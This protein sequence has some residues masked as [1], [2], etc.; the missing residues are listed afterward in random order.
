MILSNQI[1]NDHPITE[2]E[3]S[4]TLAMGRTP[5]REA[6]NLL[7]KDGIIQLIPNKGFILRQISYED[8]IQIYQIR[9]VLDPLA[10]RLST[11]RIDLSKLEE[12]EE[13]Y[14]RKKSDWESSRQFSQELHSLIYKSCGNPYLIEMF[15]SLDFRIEAKRN[16]AWNL[17]IKFNDTVVIERRKQEHAEIIQALKE[18]NSEAAEKMSKEHISDAIRDIIRLIIPNSVNS[19]LK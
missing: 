19:E 15:E 8:I 16:S 17:W 9:E 1:S 7:S 14:L 11:E 3:L 12:I 5:I 2:L 10:T 13:K 18:K 4:K 6:L